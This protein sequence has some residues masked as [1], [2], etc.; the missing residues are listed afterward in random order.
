MISI[1]ESK[2]GKVEPI[3]YIYNHPEFWTEDRIKKEDW[4]F[5][6]VATTYGK[7]HLKDDDGKDL[8]LNELD[9]DDKEIFTRLAIIR[10]K[11]G[12]DHYFLNEIGKETYGAY[13]RKEWGRRYYW[14]SHKQEKPIRI[15]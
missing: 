14:L 5:I 6:N 11:N 12:Q 3:N 2:S 9:I 7:T 10:T 4:R 15:Q 8:Y 1:K 13:T